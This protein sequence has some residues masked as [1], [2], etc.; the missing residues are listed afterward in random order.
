MYARGSYSLFC[1]L[2]SRVPDKCRQFLG[3]VFDGESNGQ[4]NF[5]AVGDFVCAAVVVSQILNGV[6]GN[7]IV[8]EAYWICGWFPLTDFNS[9]H[10][11]HA[12]S[13]SQIEFPWNFEI[14]TFSRIMA[15]P[16][17]SRAEKYLWV[18]AGA[19]FNALRRRGVVFLRFFASFYL[20]GAKRSP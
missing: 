4:I 10:S 11:N 1:T 20:Y 2:K 9:W 13:W 5:F 15:A 17:R 8:W 12:I 3:M 16:S 7:V 19:N 14:S 6:C 18:L